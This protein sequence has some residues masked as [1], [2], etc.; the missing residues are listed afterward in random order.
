MKCIFADQARGWQRNF[1]RKPRH[2]AWT[3]KTFSL[4]FAKLEKIREINF[5]MIKN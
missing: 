2:R 4:K 3:A 1:F 5:R